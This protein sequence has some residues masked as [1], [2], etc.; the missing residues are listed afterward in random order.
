MKALGLL[1]AVCGWLIS[2][3]GLS[4]ASSIGGRLALSIIGIAICLTGIFAFVNRAYMKE[5]IWKK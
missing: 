5:A 3:A 4:W 1:L 2:I